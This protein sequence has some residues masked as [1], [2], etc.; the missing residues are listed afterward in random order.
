[1]QWCHVY[2]YLHWNRCLQSSNWVV[3]HPALPFCHDTSQDLFH[4]K[5][6]LI[7]CDVP[8]PRTFLCGGFL[9]WK[10]TFFHECWWGCQLTIDLKINGVLFF[11]TV[12][13]LE[14]EMRDWKLA[15]LLRWRAPW[16]VML[17]GV[18]LAKTC[19]LWY[20]LNVE[21]ASRD[22]GGRLCW[23]YWHQLAT[24]GPRSG[25]N[26]VGEKGYFEA[27]AKIAEGQNAS[28]S[29][30]FEASGDGCSQNQCQSVQLLV[31]HRCF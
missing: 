26:P 14:N 28:K 27:V 10:P 19:V 23:A 7:F 24:R 13:A 6:A 29:H 12:S 3:D 1:M 25:V 31:S 20:S 16:Q 4:G 2:S 15:F 21:P 17:H 5:S 9:Y 8:F 30:H 18:G 22:L 11:V